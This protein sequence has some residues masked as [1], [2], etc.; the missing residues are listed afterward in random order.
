MKK[1]TRNYKVTNVLESLPLIE[2]PKRDIVALVEQDGFE[3][4]SNDKRFVVEKNS[5][6]E[7]NIEL[8]DILFYNL[9]IFYS[10]APN[11]FPKNI[12]LS[13]P[14][15]SNVYDMISLYYK[16]MSLDLPK[17]SVGGI[18]Y[19]SINNKKM[20]NNKAVVALSGGK[21]S[22]YALVSAV[23]EY[24]SK[25]VVAVH[26]NSIM[27]ILPKEE[28]ES[29]KIICEMLGVELVI[30]PIHY[31]F[32]KYRGIYNGAEIAMSTALIIPIAFD[33]GAKHVILGTLKS[34][35]D[36]Y[37]VQAPTFS[38]TGTIRDLFNVF[39]KDLGV[40][41]EIESG[42]LDTKESLINL[43]KNNSD[44]MKETISCM[45]LSHIYASHKYRAIKK[46]PDFPFYKRMCGVC[47]KCMTINVFRLRYDES[48]QHLLINEHVYK[49]C[50]H[51]FDVMNRKKNNF[52]SEVVDE[53]ED[54]LIYVMEKYETNI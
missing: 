51:V 32:K 7:R 35:K 46:Y 21:D 24:G 28:L 33:I 2:D 31:S 40:D 23:E 34:E 41:I 5:F 52:K 27:K 1:T 54:I 37:D 14:L 3:I 53:M 16:R 10:I 19:C 42:V 38:E 39:L 20:D 12:S 36:I 22:V 9:G 18:E 50:K 6:Y 49:Y 4:I 8:F 15:N 43:M 13:R 26:V 17:Y 44:I 30:I 11:Y 47:P 29:S 45:M 48:I 25:N